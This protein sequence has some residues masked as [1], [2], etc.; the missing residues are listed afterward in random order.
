MKNKV[1]LFIPSKPDIKSAPIP[2]EQGLLII[3]NYNQNKE[4]EKFLTELLSTCHNMDKVFVDDG[5]NDESWLIAERLGLKVLRHDKNLGVGAAIRTG[6]VYAQNQKGRYTFVAIMS[7]NGKM[8]ANE[9]QKIIQPLID[10]EAD[11]VQG[12]RFL[13]GG[14]SLSLSLFRSIAIPLFTLVVDLILLKRFTDITCG[15]RAYKLDWLNN[16]KIML[17]QQWLNKYELEFYIHY[18]ACRLKLKI[19][20]VP[21]TIDY[22]HLEKGRKSKIKPFSGW[23]SM[24]RPFIFLSLRIKS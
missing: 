23:W 2:V 24:V 6:I 12:S 4:V 13:N 15:F 1:D 19:K 3:V 8:Q 9:L 22:S 17:D 5:S 16:P 21:V 14:Q 10:N 18:W 20:E 7:S 11:Y